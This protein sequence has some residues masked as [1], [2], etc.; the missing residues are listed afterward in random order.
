MRRV[1]RGHHGAAVL[2]FALLLSCAGKDRVAHKA[3]PLPGAVPARPVTTAPKAAGDFRWAKWGD[4]MAEVKQSEEAKA[5]LGNADTL[6]YT[7]EVNSLEASI[8]YNFIDDK[9]VRGAYVFEGRHSNENRRIDE[10]NGLKSL[11]QEKYGKP[12]SDRMNWSR[13]LYRDDPGHWGLAVSVGDLSMWADW[14]TQQTKIR[15]G[16]RGDNFKTAL[17]LAYSSTRFEALERETAKKKAMAGM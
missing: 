11:L 3:D 2:A 12:Q 13:N 10:Y 9:L 4:S 6:V 7:G 17:V 5:T 8:V 16:L 14:K 15:L 1:S